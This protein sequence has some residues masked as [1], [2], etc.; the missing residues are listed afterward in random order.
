MPQIPYK[1]YVVAASA[2][3]VLTIAV[4]ILVNGLLPPQVPLFYGLP[5]SEEQ[6][7]PTLGLVIPGTFA[8][9]I[10][11]L[12]VLAAMFLTDEFLKK[13]L[14]ASSLVAAFFA[15]VTTL[16]IIWLIH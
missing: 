4:V 13:T 6:L 16:K 14:I 10:C 8:L 1:N 12:N 9:A 5:E 3:S 11:G 2:V 7:A 15:A